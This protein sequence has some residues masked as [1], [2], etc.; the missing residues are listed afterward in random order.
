MNLPYDEQANFPYLKAQAAY[1]I[2]QSMEVNL[3]LLWRANIMVDRSKIVLNP[4]VD[5][6]RH[7]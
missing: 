4:P 3:A 5:L 1:L 7:L 2:R 6:Q